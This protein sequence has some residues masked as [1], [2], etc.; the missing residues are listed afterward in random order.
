MAC[1]CDSS[2]MVEY[3]ARASGVPHL[4]HL[5]VLHYC[6]WSSIST[7]WLF[8]LYL[9]RIIPH[10]VPYVWEV[11]FTFVLLDC[12]WLATRLLPLEL[13]L[14]SP[15]HW[16]LAI[17]NNGRPSHFLLL[18]EFRITKHISLVPVAL[19]IREFC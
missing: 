5:L 9:H 10:S 2:E 13:V 1:I 12:K 6:L 19:H 15:L 16:L 7:L 11:D 14:D 3:L 4:V 17:A 8:L 18:I